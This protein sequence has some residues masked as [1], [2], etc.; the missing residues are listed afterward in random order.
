MASDF[1][2][3]C[4]RLRWPCAV[5]AVL[6]AASGCQKA[7]EIAHYK[8]PKE[9]EVSPSEGLA[10]GA[11]NSGE[12]G[13]AQT[14]RMLA[15]IVPHG[16]KAWFFKLSG[17]AE[18]VGKH[19]ETFQTLIQSVSFPES[20]GG[21]PQWKLPDGWQQ[22]S[23]SEMRYA[24]L[25][26]PSEAAVVEGAKAG[27]AAA[28]P[29]EVSVTSLPWSSQGQSEQLLA[30][31]NRWRGQMQLKPL[32]AEELPQ[33]T[34][35]IDLAAGDSAGG[36]KA[37]LIDLTGHMTGGMTPP[38]ASS[39]NARGSL[40]AGHPLMTGSLP[41][42]H[43]P[44]TDTLS[45]GH[46]PMADSATGTSGGGGSS[47]SAADLPFSFTAP[48]NWHA[49]ATPMFAV[50]AFSLNKNSPSPEVTITPLPQTPGGI[51]AN[52]T[53]WRGQ[54]HLPDASADELAAADKPYKV[55]GET[56]HLIKL[57]GPEGSNPQR[58][59]LTVVVSHED[60]NWIFALKAETAIADNEQANFEKFVESVKFHTA[61]K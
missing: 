32:T 19:S 48:K 47:Q 1:A 23:G 31:V 57:V 22:K 35:T 25:V 26:V 9:P 39:T 33:E 10:A 53:R 60:V 21:K 3:P 18:A 49:A 17:L 20:A 30:N 41:P 11:D 56:A 15:A 29:L 12:A 42:G 58:E 59:I 40:P 61:E 46:P 34:K 5:L 36:G 37:T 14:D 7:A 52:I 4:R 24:T 44:M 51:A 28:I 13:N 55:D 6:M 54:L 27:G 45:A 43:P 16:D 50:A 8:V 38:F 2:C